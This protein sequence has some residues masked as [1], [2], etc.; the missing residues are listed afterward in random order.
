[1]D[2]AIRPD[3]AKQKYGSKPDIYIGGHNII[4]ILLLS[5]KWKKIPNGSHRGQ[6]AQAALQKKK[7]I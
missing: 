2:G 1:V 3:A 7:S 5:N 4:G 6:R